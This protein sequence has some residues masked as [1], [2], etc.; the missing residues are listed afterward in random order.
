MTLYKCRTTSSWRTHWVCPL[1]AHTF[2]YSNNK[3][4]ERMG[5]WRS[6]RMER[7]LMD[8]ILKHFNYTY[9]SSNL[10][11]VQLFANACL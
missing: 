8:T 11:G 7:R 3:H 2:S 6:E 10:N 9:T 5:G 1:T 4:M